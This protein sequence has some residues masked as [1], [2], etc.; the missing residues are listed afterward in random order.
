MGYIIFLILVFLS[1]FLIIAIFKTSATMSNKSKKVIGV[2]LLLVAILIGIYN[3]WQEQESEQFG[4][5]QSAFN[6]GKAIPCVFEGKEYQITNNTFNF[7]NGTMSFLGKPSS[8]F[9]TL[10][11][12][13]KNCSVSESDKADNDRK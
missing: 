2:C 7:N 4:H 5:I 12:P 6:Q 1:V 10:I 13:L 3:L 8:P 11:I 9:N